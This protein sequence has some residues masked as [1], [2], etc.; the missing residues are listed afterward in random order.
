M[1]RTPVPSTGCRKFYLCALGKLNELSCPV[2]LLFDKNIKK[3]NYA[4]QVY[5]DE[6]TTT[7]NYPTTTSGKNKHNN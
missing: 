6:T 7:T 3:C 1:D 2:G 5:C 4:N